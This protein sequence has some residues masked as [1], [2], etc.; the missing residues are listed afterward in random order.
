MKGILKA[1]WPVPEQNK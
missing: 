1:K